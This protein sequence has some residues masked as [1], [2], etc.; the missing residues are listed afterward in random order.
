MKIITFLGN[1]IKNALNITGKLFID[2]NSD[3]IAFE[4]DSEA[5]TAATEAPA[6]KVIADQ[7]A[8]VALIG[9][10]LGDYYRKS[11]SNSSAGAH[12][13]FRDKTSADT[14]GAII[15]VE[16]DN[17]TDDQDAI[18]IQNDGTGNGIQINQNGDH[19]ALDID[20]NINGAS[21][22]STRIIQ[23]HVTGGCVCLVLDQDDL[24][25]GFI[26]FVGSDRG[27]VAACASAAS[28]RIELNG[29]K[30]VIPLFPDQ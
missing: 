26:D 29:T 11:V 7:G 10:D 8:H 2:Q 20:K 17:A 21:Y 12:W 27:V 19:Y 28:C 23:N 30:Y 6:F 9:V 24:S 3:E 14:N 15:F 22:G 13:F 16:Q 1:F 18:K 25:E 5:T 4:I